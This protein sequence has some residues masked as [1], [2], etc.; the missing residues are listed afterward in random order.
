MTIPRFEQT[1]FSLDAFTAAA[2][3]VRRRSS[4]ARFLTTPHPS[5][6]VHSARA[7]AGEFPFD[8]RHVG[9]QT[10]LLEGETP[11][12]LI[13]AAPNA[14]GQL[15][16]VST[17]E[18]DLPVIF[19]D[20]LAEAERTGAIPE[21]EGDYAIVSVPQIG[22]TALWLPDARVLISVGPDVLAEMPRGAV[23]DE[24]ALKRA[25]HETFADTESL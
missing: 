2:A 18:G 21:D 10:L 6:V 14:M 1:P 5:Y 16:V 13:E 23:R 12:A 4:A 11:C 22:L 25:V 15:S 7:L 20:A 24:R 19:V 8:G 9:W 3:G 17:I